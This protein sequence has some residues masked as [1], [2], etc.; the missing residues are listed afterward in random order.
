MDNS[1]LDVRGINHKYIVV[2][3]GDNMNQYKSKVEPTLAK[4][5]TT[6]IWCPCRGNCTGGCRSNCWDACTNG[7]SSSSAGHFRSL[8]LE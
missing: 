2:G 7:C 6:R 8:E 1:L 3:G 4:D 5:G